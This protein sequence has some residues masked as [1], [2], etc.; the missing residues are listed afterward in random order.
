MPDSQRYV[1][2]QVPGQMFEQCRHIQ[3]RKHLKKLVILGSGKLRVQL[4]IEKIVQKISN[5]YKRVLGN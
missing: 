5:Y 4:W 2:T 1:H 3:H